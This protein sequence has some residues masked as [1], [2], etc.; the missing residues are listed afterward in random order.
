MSQPEYRNYNIFALR[1]DDQTSDTEVCETLDLPYE[2]AGTPQI[3]EAAIQAMHRKNV[4]GYLKKGI[5]EDRAF[6]MANEKADAI[7]KEIKELI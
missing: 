2:L 4:E 7:R 3:N 6:I 5:P 1:G